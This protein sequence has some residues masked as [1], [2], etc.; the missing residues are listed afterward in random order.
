MKIVNLRK[1]LLGA[2]CFFL[3]VCQGT[4]CAAAMERVRFESAHYRVGPLQQRLAR[5][6]GETIAQPP[7]D[8][9]DGYL[10]KPDSGGP[11]PAIIALHGCS[12]L[13]EEFQTGTT[14]SSWA[15]QLTAWG[16]VVL[17]V[18]SFSSRGISEA[19][20]GPATYRVAD[21][22]GALAFLRRQPFVDP[23]LI[24]VIGFSQ[25]GTAV[26]SALEQ[27]D[28]ELFEDGDGRKFRAGVAF[29]PNCAV[30]GDMMVPTL[31]LIGELDD[32]TLASACR[33]MM[34]RLR[35]TGRPVTLIVYPG[36]HHGFDAPSLQPGRSSFG[37]WLEYN[38]AAAESA[39]REVRRFLTGNMAK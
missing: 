32:W 26:L 35:S 17:I 33:A 34:T 37:H 29:Y 31:V 9:I 11:F 7:A 22:Y 25:G 27:R 6:R 21:L 12:G 2:I 16:Y 3:S 23:A 1:L 39:I 20:A 38:P 28:S 5:E 4:D 19:C 8:V 15:D 13:S 24:A 30:D 18:D 14:R 10:V 36:A